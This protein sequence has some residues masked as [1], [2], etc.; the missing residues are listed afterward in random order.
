MREKGRDNEME[1]KRER[2]RREQKRKGESNKT[3]N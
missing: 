3:L 1:E 2:K